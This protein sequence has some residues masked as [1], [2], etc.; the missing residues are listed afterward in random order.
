MRAAIGD[1]V[2]LLTHHVGARERKRT[3]IVLAVE[4]P[5]GEPPYLVRWEDGHESTLTPG[6]D[7][8]IEHYPM[9]VVGG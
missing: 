3:A 8:V 7:A 2:V 6:V 1:K 9:E 5:S 4:G